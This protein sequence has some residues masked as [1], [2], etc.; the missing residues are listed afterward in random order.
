[1]LKSI[2]KEKDFQ[3]FFTKIIKMKWG[4]IYKIPDIWNVQKP[5]DSLVAKTDKS[6]IK[7]VELKIAPTHKTDVFRLLKDHQVSNLWQLAPYSYVLCYYKKEK[8]SSLFQVNL[9]WSLNE[10]ISLQK[11][12][13]ICDYLLWID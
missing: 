10:I 7:A 11:L 5:F 6:V 9:D 2:E 12:H 4:W 8:A 13:L 1:M 3:T